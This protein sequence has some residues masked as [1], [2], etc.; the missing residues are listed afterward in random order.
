MLLYVSQNTLKQEED[1]I[2]AFIE[3]YKNSNPHQGKRQKN[4]HKVIHKKEPA[5]T[6]QQKTQSNR[7][8]YSSN[9]GHKPQAI[10]TGELNIS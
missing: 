3:E 6:E 2:A 1:P 8:Q 10:N 5:K 9:K 7:M 4:M